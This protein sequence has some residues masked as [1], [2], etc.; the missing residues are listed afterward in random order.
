MSFVGEGRATRFEALLLPVAPYFPFFP[1]DEYLSR[2]A[3]SWV[4]DLS[5]RQCA[6]TAGGEQLPASLSRTVVSVQHSSEVFGRHEEI[7]KIAF[8]RRQ[9]FFFRVRASVRQ[10]SWLAGGQ[11]ANRHILLFALTSTRVASKATDCEVVIGHC[12][13]VG[14]L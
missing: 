14:R 8:R 12:F 1:F 9:F 5:G 2:R 7:E 6:G 11:A 3:C 10:T 4:S 13:P